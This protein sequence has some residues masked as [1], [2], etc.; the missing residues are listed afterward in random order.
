MELTD[1][2]SIDALHLATALEIGEDLEGVVTYD[3]R[4]IR[5]ASVADLH[6][7]TPL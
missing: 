5:A 3:E 7:V 1:L 4:M 2:R 6:V